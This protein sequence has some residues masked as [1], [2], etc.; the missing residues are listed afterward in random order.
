M[1]QSLTSKQVNFAGRYVQG[2]QAVLTAFDG[3]ELLKNEWDAN[4]YATGASPS[5]NNLTDA[6]LQ[7]NGYAYLTALQV[8]QAVGAVESLRTTLA[9]NRGYLEALRP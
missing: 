1:A 9:A 5:G 8:N 2:I 6:L 7:S 3:L 4:A